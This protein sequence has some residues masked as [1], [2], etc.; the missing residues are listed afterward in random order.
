MTLSGGGTYSGG[1]YIN[2]GRIITSTAGSL[3]SGAV[4]VMP[5]GVIDLR[6]VAFANTFNIAASNLGVMLE[7]SATMSGTVNLL[8]NSGFTG[9]GTGGTISGQ[10]TGAYSLAFVNGTFTLS[11][12]NNNYSGDISLGSGPADLTE[13]NFNS[14]NATLKMGALNALAYGTG[15]GNVIISAA[16]TYTSTLDLN[17]YNTTINGLISGGP[18]TNAITN[19]SATAATLTLGG[20]DQTASYGGTILAGTGVTAVTKIGAGTQT[21]SGANTY[22]GVTTISA[23]TLILASSGTIANSSGVNLGTSG[24]HGTLDL[25]SKASF[26]FGSLQSVTGFGTINIGSGKAVTIAGI[27]APGNSPGQV[28]VTGNL[29]LAGTTASTFELAGNGGVKGTDFDN[30]TATGTMAYAGTL[31]IVSF[32]GYSIDT[33][34]NLTYSLFDFTGGYT[35]NFS[36]VTVAGT[37]LVFDSGTN[38]WGASNGGNTAHYTFSLA[39]GDLTVVPEPA[40]WGLLAFSLTTVMVLR[41]RRRD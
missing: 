38:T 36:G 41:R 17:G 13:T 1:T 2:N 27:F 21:L 28:N 12:T 35:G 22:T 19:T 9:N 10:I 3:G 30:T 18:G 6:T 31:S 33:N 4:T 8:G 23:G 16:S 11:N 24:S 15:K 14:S 7:T 39:S 26:D 37:A 32:G 40:T 34:I 25:T 20:N 29:A 5:G